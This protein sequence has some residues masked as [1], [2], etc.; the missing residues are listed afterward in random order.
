MD[1]R[2]D[3]SQKYSTNLVRKASAARVFGARSPQLPFQQPVRTFDEECGCRW[4]VLQ[5]IGKG[6]G[7]LGGRQRVFFRGGPMCLSLLDS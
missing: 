4:I 5:R 1:A 3:V 7:V 6:G 2:P